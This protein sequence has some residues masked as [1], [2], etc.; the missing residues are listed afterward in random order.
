[1]SAL[2]YRCAS[3]GH[4][5]TTAIETGPDTLFRMKTMNLKIWVGCPHCVSG[6]QIRPT[7]A[8]LQDDSVPLV[9]TLRRPAAA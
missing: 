6:H 5:V 7:D 3:T 9:T 8:L 4:E 2:R 1:M